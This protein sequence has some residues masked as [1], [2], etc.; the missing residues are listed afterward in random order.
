MP[1]VACITGSLTLTAAKV[2]PDSVTVAFLKRPDGTSVEIW[3]SALGD[4]IF[5]NTFD[6]SDYTPVQGTY[7]LYIASVTPIDRA[8]LSSFGIDTATV[9]CGA[10]VDGGSWNPNF[11]YGWTLLSQLTFNYDPVV[12][13]VGAVVEGGG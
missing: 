2:Y 8:K 9:T 3:S 12:D 10:P 11:T 5:S 4:T 13:V 1:F 6:I 7:V